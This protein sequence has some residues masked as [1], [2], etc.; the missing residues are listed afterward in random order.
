M[1]LSSIRLQKGHRTPDGPQFR[2][3]FGKVAFNV[4]ISQ[5]LTSHY[6]TPYPKTSRENREWVLGMTKKDSDYDTVYGEV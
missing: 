6:S 5:R 2:N 4:E 3:E 1:T